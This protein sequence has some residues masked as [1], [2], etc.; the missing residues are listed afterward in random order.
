[1]LPNPIS[2]CERDK[3]GGRRPSMLIHAHACECLEC[4]PEP[5]V[6]LLSPLSLSVV[7]QTWFAYSATLFSCQL[8]LFESAKK[9]LATA[10]RLIRSRWRKNGWRRAAACRSGHGCCVR[11]TLNI[12]DIWCIQSCRSTAV[13]NC[14]TVEVKETWHMLTSE[15][16]MAVDE[17]CSRGVWHREDGITDE[18]IT[19]LYFFK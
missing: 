1:M 15:E 12:R 18:C 16:E 7:L 19:C 11:S 3:P 4:E 5:P 6:I 13:L 14:K 2:H 9:F 8:F 10:A 17:D